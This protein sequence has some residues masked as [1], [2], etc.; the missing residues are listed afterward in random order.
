[1]VSGGILRVQAGLI[2][3]QSIKLIERATVLMVHQALKMG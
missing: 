1:M 2:V 3:G